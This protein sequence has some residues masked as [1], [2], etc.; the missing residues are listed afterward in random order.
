LY[1]RFENG[2]LNWPSDEKEV[3]ELNS[4]QVE[5]LMK[6]FSITPIIKTRGPLKTPVFLQ[7]ESLKP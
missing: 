5:W 2:K 6:G 7:I 1:K 3:K 4:E